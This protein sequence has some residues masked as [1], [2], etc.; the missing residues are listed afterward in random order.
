MPHLSLANQGVRMTTIGFFQ[1]LFNQFVA[2]LTAFCVNVPSAPVPYL[3][4]PAAGTTAAVT[5]AVPVRSEP[6]LRRVVDTQV[7]AGIAIGRVLAASADR[8]TFALLNV[9]SDLASAMDRDGIA[10]LPAGVAQ[11]GQR[12]LLAVTDSATD[13]VGTLRNVGLSE[14]ALIPGAGAQQ[15]A[16]ATAELVAAPTAELVAPPR[17]G[18]LLE[19][20]ARVPL[21]VGVAVSDLAMSGLQA[22]ATVTGSIAKATT[23]VVAAAVNP[24]SEETLGQAI[25]RVPA[26][27][28]KGGQTAVGQL[29][30]GAK[31]AV[32]DFRDTLNPRAVETRVAATGG[33]NT[34]VAGSDS[35]GGTGTAAAV[36][37]NS[38]TGKKLESATSA[39]TGAA[40]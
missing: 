28:I 10:A 40:K 17:T 35:S 8:A 38:S 11:S 29:R 19:T 23:D 34:E 33:L 9:P 1:Q 3:G 36:S 26:T 4:S 5:T 37:N 31:R 22:V 24:R 18:G 27:L 14:L 12:I 6:L 16:T 25:S 21:A 15:R 7:Q 30:T 39:A 2:V 13:L 20:V 32:T